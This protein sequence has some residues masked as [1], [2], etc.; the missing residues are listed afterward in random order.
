M[1]R[2]QGFRFYTLQP[3]QLTVEPAGNA[4]VL[5]SW[6]GTANGYVLESTTNLTSGWSAAINPPTLFA[7]RFS[8]TN[9]VTGEAQFFRLRRQ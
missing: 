2:V 5:L 7:G 3:P 4:E 1:V 8:V 9:T 6:P